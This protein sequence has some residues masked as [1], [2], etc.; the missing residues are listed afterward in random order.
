M[1]QSLISLPSTSVIVPVFN[2]EK[3]LPRLIQTLEG[4]DYPEEKLEVFLVDNNSTDRTAE[5]IRGSGFNYLSETGT[6]SSYAARN[7]GVE[8]ARGEVLAFTD[9]DCEVDPDWLKN[10]I[11]CMVEEKADMVAGPVEWLISEPGNMCEI[12]DRDQ[13]GR[14]ED[15]VGDGFAMTANVLIRRVV[16]EKMGLFDERM[17]SSGDRV[18]TSLATEAG[19]ILVYCPQA[20][21]RHRAR[22]TLAALR[23]KWWRVG[24]GYGQETFHYNRGAYFF[25]DWRWY[26]PGIRRF[27]GIASR[28]RLSPGQRA[29]L[30]FVDWLCKV[31]YARGNRAGYLYSR[32]S[33]TLPSRDQ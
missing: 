33:K 6:Q 9:S 23:R 30:F 32:N 26:V 8:A 22:R 15:F 12:Y 3:T 2:G 28:N 5:I 25:S 20:S 18:Y 7:R 4:L 29:G 21:V 14:Q 16:F 13:F 19:F 31:A 1:N 24:F 17:A 10:G 11:R 27:M